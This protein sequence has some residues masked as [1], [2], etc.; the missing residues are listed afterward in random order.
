MTRTERIRKT[1]ALIR[2]RVMSVGQAEI[3]RQTNESE[4]KISRMMNGDLS[5][6]VQLL[7]IAGLKVVSQSLVCHDPDYIAGLR[8]FAE[9]GVNVPPQELDYDGE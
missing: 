6:Y 7:E 1:E 2:R 4:S 9:I 5:V 8:R 3:A